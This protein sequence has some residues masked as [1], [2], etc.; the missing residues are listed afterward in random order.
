[1]PITGNSFS[2]NR[3]LVSDNRENIERHI[4][5]S[6]PAEILIGGRLRQLCGEIR[7]LPPP[8]RALLIAQFHARMQDSWHAA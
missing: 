8:R 7:S 2:L 3:E 1:M 6:L 5:M 4:K